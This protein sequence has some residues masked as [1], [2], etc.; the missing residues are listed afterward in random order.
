M[1][2]TKTEIKAMAASSLNRMSTLMNH[3]GTHE[4]RKTG[5]RVAQDAAKMRRRAER[6]RK[7]Y[8]RLHGM[9]AGF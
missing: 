3:A 7:A 8:E 2:I 1:K 9:A 5:R 4:A 6:Y